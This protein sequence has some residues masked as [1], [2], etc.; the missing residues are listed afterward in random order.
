MKKSIFVAIAF[1]AVTSIT[2][3]LFAQE[4]ATMKTGYNVKANVK[5]R[6][7]ATET[8]CSIVFDNDVKSPRDAASGLATGKRGYDY[9]KAISEFSVSAV[10]NSVTEV[11]S[12]RDA[13]SGQ[14][15][16]KRQHRPITITKE[17]DKSS[18]KLD[19]SV[20]SPDATGAKLGSGGGS[21]K[22]N[23]QDLSFS[24]VN[25]QD[26]S[27]TKRCAGKTT[28]LSVTDGECEIPTG[29]CPN[30]ECTLICSWSWGMS[31][32]GSSTAGSGSS[33]R[34][35]TEFILQIEDGVCTSMAINEKGLPGDKKPATTKK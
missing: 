10:D 28:K 22:V 20:S 33:G 31:Q 25:V 9:Y 34:C 2:S 12:P 7:I 29:D 24:K 1:M 18:P 13:A 6:V 3:Q 27:F 32:S 35:T 11:K 14:A 5:C 21:G 26:I 4:A 15:T 23:V 16:G 30:G 19:E 17:L 8:G